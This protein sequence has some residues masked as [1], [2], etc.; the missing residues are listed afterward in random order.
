MY[1]HVY[2]VRCD[3]GQRQSVRAAA[4]RVATLG[5]MTEPQPLGDATGEWYYC[6]KH[7]KVEQRDDCDQMDRLGP[8]PTREDAA[9]WRERVA[10]R[11]DAWD[12]DDE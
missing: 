10:A 9:N 12:E 8:Y 1:L 2:H 4:G 5:A 3:G 6:F 11:N 7:A